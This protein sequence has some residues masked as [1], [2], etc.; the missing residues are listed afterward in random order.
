MLFISVL[1]KG[2]KQERKDKIMDVK[3]V[4]K[5]AVR[6]LLSNGS[7]DDLNE[8]QNALVVEFETEL[9]KEKVDELRDK[10][11][12]EEIEETIH[13]WRLDYKIADET[14][15]NLSA[16][17]YMNT[18]FENGDKMVVYPEE[19]CSYGGNKND[20]EK[21]IKEIEQ[22]AARCTES[23]SDGYSWIMRICDAMREECFEKE[24][25]IST[26]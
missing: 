12:P 24:N 25:Q 6:A 2:R 1:N 14:E 4:M 22:I 23:Q 15:N 13:D 3:E 5:K 17:V 18:K 7:Y 9:W 11:S 20:M 10:L 21:Y 8:E 19:I 26:I 16:Y